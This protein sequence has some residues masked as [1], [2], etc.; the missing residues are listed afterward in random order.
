MTDYL[1]ER[2]FGWDPQPAPEGPSHFPRFL[3]DLRLGRVPPP[4]KEPQLS[5]R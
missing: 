2:P 3:Q 5:Q 1:P 4:G